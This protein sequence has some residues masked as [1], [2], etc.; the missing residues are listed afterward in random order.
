MWAAVS[1]PLPEGHT[2][3]TQFPSEEP[4]CGREAPLDMSPSSATASVQLTVLEPF[5]VSGMAPVLPHLP[6][7]GAGMWT[8]GFL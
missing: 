1:V 3:G 5:P 6:D 7:T 2:V 4:E 8:S